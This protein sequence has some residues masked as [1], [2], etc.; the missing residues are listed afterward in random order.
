[1][2][3]DFDERGLL[4][5]G[6]H[7]ATLEELDEHFGRFQR[8]D[9]R[10]TLFKKLKAY[11]TDLKNSGIKC[12][13]I[14]D[15]SFIMTKVDEPDDIDLVLILPED[16]DME[17]NLRPYQYNVVSKRRVRQEYRFDLYSVRQNSTEEQKWIEFFGR[18][19]LKWCDAFNWVRETRKG[20]VRVSI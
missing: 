11:L 17:A 9:Q 14:I 16:W 13:L 3:L 2:P 1:M 19:N 5:P 12:S 6:V 18:V 7:D 4:L 15:G 20:L 10:I 8:T